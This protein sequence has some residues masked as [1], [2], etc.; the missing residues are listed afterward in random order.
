MAEPQKAQKVAKNV[1]KKF[2]E[3]SSPMTATKIHLYSTSLEALDNKV[4]KLDLSRSMRGK[5]V[6]LLLRVKLK[7]GELVGEPSGFFV[8]GSYIRKII[9]RG[10]DY[11]EDSFKTSTR[12]SEVL[13]KIFLMTR[14]KVSRAIQTSLRN[15]TKDFIVSLFKIR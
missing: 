7:G 4:V 1:K 11:V 5:N 14:H 3:V 2:Y 9:R 13:V 6:D 15:E 10:T 8:L 12:D